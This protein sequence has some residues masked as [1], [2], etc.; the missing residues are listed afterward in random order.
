M[1]SFGLHSR[2][3]HPKFS[4]SKNDVGSSRSTSFINFF[5]MGA[6]FFFLP[7]IFLPIRTILVS[8]EQTS[9]PNSVLLPI[10]VPQ[11]PPQIVFS[12]KRPASGWS[13]KF[14]S[15]VTT[16]SSTF[17]QDLG[18]LCR[19]RRIHMS[20]HY[21]FGIFNNLGASS[22]LQSCSPAVTS[23]TFAAVICE[24]DDPCSVNTA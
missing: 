6:I 10:P 3:V 19:G 18:H 8:D 4:W 23:I 17:D 20:G 22:I 1:S 21:D 5:H 2:W 15:R 7:A 13:Y 9:I 24:A 11:E 16:A 12:H 14:R